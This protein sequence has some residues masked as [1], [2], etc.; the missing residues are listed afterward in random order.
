MTN[1]VGI[2][3]A[4][5]VTPAEPVNSSPTSFSELS[6]EAQDAIVWAALNSDHT[7]SPVLSE[8]VETEIRNWSKHDEG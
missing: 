2:T 1:I 7:K 6:K 8:A 5:N 3:P 4:Q